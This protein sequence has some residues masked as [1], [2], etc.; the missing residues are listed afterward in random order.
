MQTK[1]K[2]K[3]DS[4]VITKGVKIGNDKKVRQKFALFF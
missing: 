3:Y 2:V 4:L 1:E